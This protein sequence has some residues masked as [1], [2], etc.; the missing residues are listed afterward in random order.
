MSERPFMYI[1]LHKLSHIINLII[2]F[3]PNI[4]YWNNKI[5]SFISV[6][7]LHHICCCLVA[8]SCT[9]LSWPPWTVACQAP[10]SMEFSMQEY[11]RLPFPYPGDLPNP[12]IKLVSP[13]L[14]GRF[15]L[16][17]HQESPLI[18]YSACRKWVFN[19]WMKEFQVL[20]S[21]SLAVR[22]NISPGSKWLVEVTE[23]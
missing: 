19:N 3:P 22:T 4:V 6:F 5:D 12:G 7:C 16:L 17:S 21:T 20:S 8:K 9:N 1:I 2:S 11:W 15:F 14:A 23:K 10:L 13:A 18:L